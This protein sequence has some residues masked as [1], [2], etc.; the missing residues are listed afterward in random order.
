MGVKVYQHINTCLPIVI[1]AQDGVEV[2]GRALQTSSRGVE[3][4]CK[5]SDRN[6]VTPGGS[7]IRDGRPIKI[8]V[9]LAI[10]AGDHG[11]EQVS[12]RCHITYSRRI[13]KDVCHIGLRYLDFESDGG[14][15]LLNFIESRLA[16][17]AV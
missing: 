6:L 7:L 13:A 3:V 11:A 10:P 1:A 16:F 15:K 2:E 9:R 14:D 17:N 4:Q 12:A 5:T 8:S